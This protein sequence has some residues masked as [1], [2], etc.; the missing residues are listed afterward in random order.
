MKNVID[1]EI[2]WKVFLEERTTESSRTIEARYIRINP[3][4]GL[5]PELDDVDSLDSLPQLASKDVSEEAIKNLALHLIA[6]TFYFK[7]AVCSAD[8]TGGGYT[9]QGKDSD[10]MVFS[11]RLALCCHHTERLWRVN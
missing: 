8:E 5:V 11:L 2:A 10:F 6:S 1:A 7:K 9:C 3:D 4:I